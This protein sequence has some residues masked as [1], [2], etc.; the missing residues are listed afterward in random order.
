MTHK[1]D[2]CVPM[3]NEDESVIKPL[4][5][6]IAV[7]RGVDLSEVGV[8][9]CCDGG[10]ARLSQEFMDSYI[11]DVEFHLCEHRGVSATRNTCMSYST[12]DYLMWCDCDDA[13]VD[14]RG[15]FII[16]REMEAM[17]SEQEMRQLGIPRDKWEPGFDYMISAFVE[18]THDPTTGELTYLTHEFDQVFTHGKVHRRQWLIDNDVKWGEQLFVHEDS[19]MQALCRAVARPD[20][21]KY[22]P[23]PYYVWC[24][25]TESVCRRSPKDYILSTYNNLIDSND[26]LVDELVRRMLDEQASQYAVMLIF[27]AFYLMNRA[28]WRDQQNQSYRLA[29]EERFSRYY[30]K[31]ES[32][33]LK[34]DE[35]QKAMISSGVRQRS[36]MEGMLLEACSVEQW[37]DGILAKFPEDSA[38]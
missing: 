28:E 9:V 15:L 22:C 3:Y 12:A 4:L 10:T 16:F 38:T 32:K 34:M 36:V 18:E 33:W 26:C 5:D 27:D 6:S 21:I 31:H 17:P 8:I 35:H 7:Q 13:F 20:R 25:R 24:W 37:I 23:H 19:Y 11:F 2:I 14:T 29:V 30:R 1:L